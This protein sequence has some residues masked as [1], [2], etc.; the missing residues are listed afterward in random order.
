MHD[1]G[2]IIYIYK[3]LLRWFCPCTHGIFVWTVHLHFIFASI[4]SLFVSGGR[5]IGVPWARRCN[6]R[7]ITIYYI[8]AT[9][10]TITVSEYKRERDREAR[11]I[12]WPFKPRSGVIRLSFVYA[13]TTESWCDSVIV[14][15]TCT[16]TYI[17][18]I[19]WYFSGVAQVMRF[20]H[21]HLILHAT[22][23]PTTHKTSCVV[24]LHMNT[25]L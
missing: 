17:C 9:T 7:T 10:T 2:Y 5:R 11:I 21:S 16:S 23:P 4:F 3:C 14:T 8:R 1:H 20:G 18:G 15:L 12:R 6:N 24:T 13:A 22:P 19:D 25:K